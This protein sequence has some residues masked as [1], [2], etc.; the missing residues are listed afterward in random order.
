MPGHVGQLTRCKPTPSTSSLF[1]SVFL[2][3]K[4]T[5]RPISFKMF[6]NLVRHYNTKRLINFH[7]LGTRVKFSTASR[8]VKEEKKLWYFFLLYGLDGFI[9]SPK[10]LLKTLYGEHIFYSFQRE[11]I[12]RKIG[13]KQLSEVY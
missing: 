12:Y 13:L 6:T 11:M 9:D 10:L 4:H 1:F 7:I 3:L 8:S 5:P 2:K